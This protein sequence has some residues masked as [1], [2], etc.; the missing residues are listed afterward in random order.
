MAVRRILAV[1]ILAATVF[2]RGAGAAAREDLLYRLGEIEVT[3]SVSS[4]LPQDDVGRVIQLLERFRVAFGDLP[5]SAITIEVNPGVRVPVSIDIE[6]PAAPVEGPGQPA[7]AE[8]RS[9]LIPAEIP[10]LPAPS[11]GVPPVIAPGTPSGALTSA[12]PVLRISAR[13]LPSLAEALWQIWLPGPNDGWFERS[14]LASYVQR[15]MLFGAGIIGTAGYRLAIDDDWSLYRSYLKP[16]VVDFPLTDIPG[17]VPAKAALAKGRLFLRLL[18][19]RIQAY[20]GGARSLLDVVRIGATTGPGWT[21]RAA[22][23]RASEE[24]NIPLMPLY[25]RF[26]ERGETIRPDELWETAVFVDGKRLALDVSPRVLR[27]R[28]L[29]PIRAIFEAL[30]A[31]VTWDQETARVTAIRGERT[32][33]LTVGSLIASVDEKRYLLDVAPIISG[34]RVLVPLRFSGEAFG[35]EVGW[36][37]ENQTIL[38]SSGLGVPISFPEITGNSA[39]GRLPGSG[40]DAPVVYLTFDDGPTHQVTPMVLDALARYNVKATFFVIGA[41]AQDHADLT[42]RIVREG[43]ALGNHTWNH[44]YSDIYRSPE[45]FLASVRRAEAALNKIAG[46]RPTLVR[47]PGG[48]YGHFTPEYFAIMKQNGYAVVNWNVSSADATLPVPTADVIA[49]NVIENS[50]AKSVRRNVVVLM[51]DGAGH[52]STAEALP[53]IIEYFLSQGYRFDVLTPDN[54][55]AK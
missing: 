17:K 48:T 53:A 26:A 47:A 14:V 11:E 3:I 6:F 51:H 22:L 28:T 36:D 54:P 24:W 30:G 35:A 37:A 25:V 50:K 7:P 21:L 5:A 34:D 41:R 16:K 29:V 9:Q 4:S 13:D 55:L 23:E 42:R 19:L 27:G 2:A 12:L 8:S 10:S 44:D 18:D 52:E 49:S 15:E 20:S 46:V 43:H 38:V 45:A 31:E 32:V 40:G 33:N 1:V 39:A